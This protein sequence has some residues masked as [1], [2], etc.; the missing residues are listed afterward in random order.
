MR[1][2]NVLHDKSCGLGQVVVFLL[3]DGVDEVRVLLP[4][5][6]RQ[7]VAVAHDGVGRDAV[8]EEALGGSVAADD[9]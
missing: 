3:A 7:G 6:R 2:A 4:D 8:A 1:W 9:V 5:D